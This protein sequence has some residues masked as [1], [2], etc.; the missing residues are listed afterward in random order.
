MNDVRIETQLRD[1]KIGEDQLKH[2]ECILAR[3]TSRP[4]EDPLMR[5]LL[6][7]RPE[8]QKRRV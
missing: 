7:G 4:D 3:E 5:D 1:R 2:Q 8:R 6:C